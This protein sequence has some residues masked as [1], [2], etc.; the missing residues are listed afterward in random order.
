MISFEDYYAR[1]LGGNIAEIYDKWNERSMLLGKPV[2]IK[3]TDGSLFGRA[4][5]IDRKGALV[6][7]DDNGKE[8]TIL[9]GDVSVK[10]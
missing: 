6:I 5:R 9:N 1:V 7:E 2:E 4:L 8:Q 3:T 10:F